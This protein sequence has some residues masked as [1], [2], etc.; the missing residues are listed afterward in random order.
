MSNLSSII[1]EGCDL[2]TIN[3]TRKLNHKY[4]YKNGVDLIAMESA[5]ALRDIFE[6]AFYIPNTCEINA[7]L[8]G[9]SCVEESSQIAIMEAAYTS[10]YNKIK[11]YYIDTKEKVIDLLKNI[12]GIL[13]SSI[14]DDKKFIETYKH[15]LKTVNF[16]NARD[17]KYEMHEYT[18]LEP[19]NTFQ[20]YVIE[21]CIKFRGCY[22]MY[23]TKFGNNEST[24]IDIYRELESMYNS[25][26]SKNGSVIFTGVVKNGDIGDITY[27]YFRNGATSENDKKPV[28][29]SRNINKFMNAFGDAKVFLRSY[30]TEIRDVERCYTDMITWMDSFKLEDAP[31]SKHLN[32]A[33]S[34]LSKI[35][36]YIG[37]MQTITNRSMIDRCTAYIERGLEYRRALTKA[38]IY[39]NEKK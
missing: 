17:F 35:S 7:A 29:V 3:Q 23:N 38:C 31:S 14:E 13:L 2:E 32:D 24:G 5:E 10:A 1:R 27:A 16:F 26:T 25:F 22:V 12:K 21:Y 36:S 33:I 11:K 6:T 15:T 4:D 37:K 19:K 20:K 8:E 34:V 30:D 39:I 9:A 18:N 28:P